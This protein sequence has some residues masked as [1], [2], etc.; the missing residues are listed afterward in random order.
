M[1]EL[2]ELQGP[3]EI[4]DLPDRGSMKLRVKGWTHGRMTIKPKR[5]GGSE[6]VEVEALRLQLFEGYKQ[7]PP[8]YYDVTAKTLI[9]QLLPVLQRPD[10]S[11]FELGITKY[12]VAPRARF[13]VEV[14]PI[15]KT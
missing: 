1:A 13:T 2:P 6:E 3:Y 15:A 10:Y 9:Y 4:L 5:L 7:V 11:M 14:S 8:F 12:G